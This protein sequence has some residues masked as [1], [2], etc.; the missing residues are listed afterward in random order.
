MRRSAWS[1][2]VVAVALLVT[3]VSDVGPGAAR[4]AAAAQPTP[5]V[6]LPPVAVVA[7]RGGADLW[8]ENSLTAFRGALALGV[9]TLELDVHVTEDGQVVVGHDGDLAPASCRDTR[10]A[11]PGDPEFP[12]V[13]GPRRLS[14]LT[15][16]QVRTVAC[17]PPS[18]PAGLPLLGEVL[19]LVRAPGAG[20]VTVDVELKVTPAEPAL[21]DR[22]VPLV[23]AEVRRAGL[24]GR[25]A[26]SSF[27]WSALLQVRAVEPRLA[28]TAL[29]SGP[30]QLELGRPGRSPWLAGLDVDAFGGD[31]VAAVAALHLD[32]IAVPHGFPLDGAAGTPGYVPFA[33]SRLVGQAHALGLR[34]QV[35]TVDDPATMRA[36]V[37]AGVDG[38]VTD[39]PDLLRAVL[40]A[41]CRSLPPPR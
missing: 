8:P 41:D 7:H 35:W 14:E 25:V 19:D 1:V 11:V 16:A 22:L 38:V 6:P 34:V 29:F 39:R 30:D 24:V 28:L 23:V 13:P 32:G 26:I 10:P 37:A 15:L 31:V 2:A 40:A 5:L 17:G 9:S 33:E 18:S 3:L 27:D 4:R 20:E 36:V 21:R 12:Y